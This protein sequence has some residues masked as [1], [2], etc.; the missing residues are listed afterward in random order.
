[1]LGSEKITVAMCD[2][3]GCSLKKP[4]CPLERKMLNTTVALRILLKKH[5]T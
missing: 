2:K 5:A 1:M 4:C 3:K